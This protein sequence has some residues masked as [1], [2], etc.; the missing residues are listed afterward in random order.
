MIFDVIVMAASLVNLFCLIAV[1]FAA[2]R[3]GL[4][5]QAASASF[6]ALLMKVTLPCTTFMSLALREY[7]P[8]FIRDSLMIIAIGLVVFP[9]ALFSSKLLAS[10]LGVRQGRRGLWIFCCTFSNSGFM[11]FPMALALFGN[12]GLALSVMLNI[13]F[14]LY[15]FTIGVM[16]INSDSGAKAGKF[17]WR[18]I[19]FSNINIALVLSLIVYFGRLTIP[20]ILTAPL[21]H[22]SQITT[23]L[24]MVITG[25]A[26][27]K[28]RGKNLFTDRD[29]WTSAAVRL[30]IYPLAIC[31]VLRFLPLSNP[32]VAAV[33]ALIFAMPAPSTAAVL[34]EMYHGDSELAAKIL[35][36]HNLLCVVTI[37]M[38]CLTLP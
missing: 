16:E 8:A 11:G 28:N 10:L 14:S 36:L 26:L 9:L 27:G 38:V 18:S 19:L 22:L 25:M 17:D 20:S 33:A 30:L 23:P 32:L 37:P 7:D 4:V 6:S 34:S 15:A 2:A 24:S 31:L 13:T 3:F 35:F 1:G 29:V 12:E 5:P 21:I